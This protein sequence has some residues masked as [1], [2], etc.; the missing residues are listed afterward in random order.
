MGLPMIVAL[1]PGG[2]FEVRL[3]GKRVEPY[4][5]T[6]DQVVT[7]VAEDRARAERAAKALEKRL[8]RR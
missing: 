2:Y 7:R 1:E 5:V 3:K 4:R 8:R 6:F